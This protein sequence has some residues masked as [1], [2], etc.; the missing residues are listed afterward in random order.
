MLFCKHIKRRTAKKSS[1]LLM[2][3]RK[4]K[5][6]QWSDFVGICMDVVCVMMEN[7]EGLHILIKRSAP[8]TVWTQCM[9]HHESLAMK[10]LC[11]E[12]TRVMKTV[13]YI[14]NH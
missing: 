11:P 8:E 4:K 1:K 5:T 6:V 14:L 10:E 12:L 9:V 3:S 2:I 13:N 7:K